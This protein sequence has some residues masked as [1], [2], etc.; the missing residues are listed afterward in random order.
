MKTHKRDFKVVVAKEKIREYMRVPTEA[1]LRLLEEL[2]L[3]KSQID[4]RNKNQR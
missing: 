2:I 3:L 1:K 4:K